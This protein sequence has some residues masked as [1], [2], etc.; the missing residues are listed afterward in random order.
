MLLKKEKKLVFMGCQVSGSQE[1]TMEDNVDEDYAN[2]TLSQNYQQT[3]ALL[4]CA[5]PTNAS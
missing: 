3:V 4:L 5:L 2:E 1:C